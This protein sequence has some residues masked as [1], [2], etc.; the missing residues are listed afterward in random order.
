MIADSSYKQELCW[1][2]HSE[3]AILW[4]WWDQDQPQDFKNGMFHKNFMCSDKESVAF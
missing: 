4:Q 3:S 2:R 1:G